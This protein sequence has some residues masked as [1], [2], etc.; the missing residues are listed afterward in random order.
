ME[1]LLA[2]VQPYMTLEDYLSE[3]AFARKLAGLLAPLRDRGRPVLAVLPEEVGAFL[4]LVGE[5]AIARRARTLEE[6]F[7][8]IARRHL[9]AVLR[10]RWRGAAD[11]RTAV[12][13]QRAAVAGPAYVRTI[14]AVARDLGIWLVGGSALLPAAIPG[15]DPPTPGSAAACVH[16]LGLVADPQGRIVHRFAKVN[17]VPGLEDHM[18]LCPAPAEDLGVFA[19]A[20]SRVGVLICYDGFVR[21]HTGAESAFRPMAPHLAARGAEILVQPAANPWPW[22]QP[23]P[24]DP[25]RLRREQWAQE[26]LEAAMATLPGVRYGVTAHLLARFFD[27]AFD[28]RSR[29]LARG[30]DG[31]VQV[32]AEAPRADADRAAETIV[33]ATVSL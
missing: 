14:S 9:G 24:L 4:G 29:L 17:L 13:L 16:N 2:A 25:A 20:G 8:R 7:R 15:L 22:D 23:W 33:S 28:G 32:L 19:F 27:V 10:A 1:V 21:P 31:S 26:S 5:A 30:S 18:G 11:L 6:A 12:L 3:A